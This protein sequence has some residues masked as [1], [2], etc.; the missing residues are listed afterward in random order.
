[1]Y[2]YV[3]CVSIENEIKKLFLKWFYNF[4]WKIRNTLHIFFF[5]TFEKIGKPLK[6]SYQVDL[7]TL[8]AK[9]A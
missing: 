8:I 5:I 7:K 6:A 9:S 3:F 4:F 2:E 1:M